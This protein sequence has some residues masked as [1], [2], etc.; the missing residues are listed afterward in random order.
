MGDASTSARDLHDKALAELGAS[1]AIF[2]P[3]RI[4]VWSDLGLTTAQ[5][6]VLFDIRQTPGVTAG[7]LATQLAVTPPT[8]SGI[9]DRLVRFELV[10]RREDAAD[11]RLVRNVLTEKGDATC[12]RFQKGA[13]TFTR[14]ILEEMDIGD[15]EG[16]VSGLSAMRQASDFVA[17][18]EPD[19]AA[20]AMPPIQI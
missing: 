15:V 8:V 17:S 4:R 16:L 6:R 20:R 12:G 7:E 10:E 1:M 3:L 11:R 19:L 13:A 5:L 2:D 9:V 18:V 14:R